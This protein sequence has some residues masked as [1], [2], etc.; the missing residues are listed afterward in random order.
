MPPQKAH[1]GLIRSIPNRE[2]MA[3]DLNKV[4]KSQLFSLSILYF[5][6]YSYVQIMNRTIKS[7][8]RDE[9]ES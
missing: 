3:E 4:R 8:K 5:E 2:P 9:N 6:S 1:T 7:L